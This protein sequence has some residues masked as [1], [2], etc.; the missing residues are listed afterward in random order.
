MLA[1]LGELIAEAPDELTVQSGFISSPDGTPV[2][3]AMPTWS[4]ALDEGALWVK[5]IEGLGAPVMSAAGPAEY[6]EPLRRGDQMFA[7]DGRHY[8]IRTRN[9]PALTAETVEDLVSDE[10][11]PAW[12]TLADAEGNEVDVAT[13]MG[14]G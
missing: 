11:Q 6:G 1:G 2:A 9:L 7:W 12:W 10:H 4:G 5:R 13:T 14:R 3:F 8:A